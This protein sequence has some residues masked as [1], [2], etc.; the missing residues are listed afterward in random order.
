MFPGES[1]GEGT[2]NNLEN[3]LKE[4]LPN[5]TYECFNVFGD[6]MNSAQVEGLVDCSARIITSV[7][8]GMY[9]QSHDMYLYLAYPPNYSGHLAL[10]A[11]NLSLE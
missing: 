10:S 8:G 1:C 2:L 5:V 9:N 6:P 4:Q 11:H 3:A 7:Q